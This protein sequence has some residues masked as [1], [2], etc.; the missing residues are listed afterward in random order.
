MSKFNIYVLASMLLTFSTSLPM[1]SCNRQLIFWDLPTLHEAVKNGTL[2]QVK[3]LITAGNINQRDE[4]GCTPLHHAIRR[5]NF[6]IIREL[7]AQGADI[8]LPQT[9]GVTVAAVANGHPTVAW[10]V[11]DVAPRIHDFLQ[12]LTTG[13]IAAT[14]AELRWHAPDGRH[15]I[16]V[17]ATTADLRSPLHYAVIYAGNDQD[18][19]NPWIQVARTLIARHADLNAQDIHGNTPLHYAIQNKNSILLR[20]LVAHGVDMTIQNNGGTTAF[21][22]DANFV[23]I[24]LF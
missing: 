23:M 10:Y 9:N 24:N 13:N 21:Q 20:Y 1:W 19:N 6:P 5:E 2:A 22:T 14:E 4:G 18:K 11:L 3:A 16:D 8:A 17:N 15:G 7:I 12:A